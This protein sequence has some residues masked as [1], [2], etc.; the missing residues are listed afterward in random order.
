MDGVTSITK[1]QF[2]EMLSRVIPVVGSMLWDSIAQRPFIHLGLFVH[3]V[4]GLIPRFYALVRD[5]EKLSLLQTSM[6]AGVSV[7]NPSGM[8]SI[9]SSFFIGRKRGSK[10]G[11]F[12]ELWAGYCGCGCIQLRDAG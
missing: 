7:E 2:Y 5:P 1:A 6:H 4:V 10:F 9:A 3:R 11:C 8:P 12:C